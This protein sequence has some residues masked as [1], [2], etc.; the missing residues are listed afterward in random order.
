M[1]FR[2]GPIKF[3]RP[4]N[5]LGTTYVT[6]L[7]LPKRPERHISEDRRLNIS[8]FT[9]CM[10]TERMNSLTPAARFFKSKEGKSWLEKYT[11]I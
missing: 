5:I 2:D 4:L 1:R 6:E 7:T 10:W 9:T 8:V 3:Q 11:T